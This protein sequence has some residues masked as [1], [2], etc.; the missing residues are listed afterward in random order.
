MKKR[1][2]KIAFQVTPEQA[3]TLLECYN[4]LT[5]EEKPVPPVDTTPRKAIQWAELLPDDVKAKF[6]AN[7]KRLDIECKS[8][9][10]AIEFGFNW[11]V[12]P[13]NY[14]YWDDIYVKALKNE[15]PCNS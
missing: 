13:E 6:L 3:A 9:Y 2:I 5:R 10:D 12:S 15:Y 8:L 14:P 11:S 7:H 4:V 1:L